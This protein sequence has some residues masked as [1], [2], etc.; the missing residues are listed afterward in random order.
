MHNFCWF[1]YSFFFCECSKQPLKRKMQFK[2]HDNVNVATYQHERHLKGCNFILIWFFH[3]SQCGWCSPYYRHRSNAEETLNALTCSTS[4]KFKII[5]CIPLLFLKGWGKSWNEVH[6][7]RRASQRSWT[8]YRE[9]YARPICTIHTTPT[10]WK[11][12]YCCTLN[13]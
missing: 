6:E 4:I 2:R 8:C 10:I 1:C 12:V 3:I 13:I 11:K 5:I 9:R 7:E